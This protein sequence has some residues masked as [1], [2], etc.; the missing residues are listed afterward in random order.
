MWQSDG[1]ERYVGMDAKPFR[2]W[3]VPYAQTVPTVKTDRL[4]VKRHQRSQLCPHATELDSRT[5]T[6]DIC[7]GTC[8]DMMWP[9]TP[10]PLLGTPDKDRRTTVESV[11]HRIQYVNAWSINGWINSTSSQFLRDHYKV[12]K[13]LMC[14][15]KERETILTFPLIRYFLPPE[16]LQGGDRAGPGRL[17]CRLYTGTVSLRPTAVCS[18]LNMQVETRGREAGPLH[19]WMMSGNSNREKPTCFWF[20]PAHSKLALQRKQVRAWRALTK[21]M[22]SLQHR[23]WQWPQRLVHLQMSFQNRCYSPSPGPTLGR[24]KRQITSF[25]LGRRPK[26]SLSS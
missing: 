11:Q 2:D 15:I 13:V 9:M 19:G 24:R 5:K 12:G 8:S 1:Q 18:Y 16:R 21:C 4:R 7:L 25:K 14:V 10:I 20:Y 23:P 22:S 3:T 6:A 17:H 26:S